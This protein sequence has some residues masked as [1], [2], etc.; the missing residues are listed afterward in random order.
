MRNYWFP[1]W[2]VGIFCPGKEIKGLRG[3]VRPYGAP[4]SPLIDTARAKKH[5]FRMETNYIAIYKQQSR[6]STTMLIL[7]GTQRNFF[8]GT[9]F[10]HHIPH[11]ISKLL[12]FNMLF[13]K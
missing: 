6:P 2:K 9:G 5:P 11:R 13:G 8:N 12:I 10:P 3:G 7:G 4:A 1:I